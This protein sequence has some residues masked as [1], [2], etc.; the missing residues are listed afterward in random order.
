MSATGP[1]TH[2]NGPVSSNAT[3]TVP[4]AEMFP[5]SAAGCSN[6]LLPVDGE[7]AWGG[8]HP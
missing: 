2:D 8:V 4:V 6:N 5:I 3:H 1:R 7:E